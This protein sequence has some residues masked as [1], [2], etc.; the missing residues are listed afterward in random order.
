MQPSRSNRRNRLRVARCVAA[1]TV[2]LGAVASCATAE[3]SAVCLPD[4][5]SVARVWNEVALDAIRLDFPAPTVHARNLHHLSVA[6]WDSWVAYDD[7]EASAHTAKADGSSASRS[8]QE[9]AIA[10]AASRILSVRYANAIGGEETVATVDATLTALCLDPAMADDPDG[11]A[12]HGVAIADAVLASAADDGSRESDLYVAPFEVANEP[13]VLAEP[14]T[15]MTEPNRWQQLLFV[16]AMTQNGQLLESNLQDYVGP[17]WGAVTPFALTPSSTGLPIDPGP[18]PLLGTATEP[19]FV[20]GAVD[21]IDASSRLDPTDGE[22]LDIGP[23]ARG[24]NSLGTN[25]GSGHAVNPSTGEPYA[26]NVV[27]AAD[28]YRVIAEFWADG[29][30]SETPPG[31]W[32][33]L[34]NTAS[35]AL[36]EY[37]LGGSGETVDRLQWDVSLYFV[38]NGALHDAAIAAWG[39]KAHYDYVRPISMIRHLAGEGELPVVPGLIEVVTEASA[40]PGGHHADLV[41]HVGEPA[42]RAWARR[43]AWFDE[44]DQVRWIPASEWKPYQRP[45]FVTPAFP[46]YVSGHST[47]SRAAAEVLTALTGSEYFPGGMATHRV[48]AGQLEFDGGPSVDIELQWATYYDAADEAGLSRIYGGIH[49]AADDV[50]GRRMGADVGQIAVDHA[51]QYLG[52]DGALGG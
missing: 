9:V 52:H 18:P 11:P 51:A 14:G 2:C 4:D 10:F 22:M 40:A 15:T 44:V 42:I 37:R 12:A 6:M 34:A 30:S 16:Q 27:P 1:I 25:D 45:T 33:T 48:E 50:E 47:F 23:G 8:D 13:L 38:L 21:V 32:N 31:H 41:D 26:A 5:R 35:D 28:F 43:P 36:E 17:H 19:E 49:V 20:S 29:P 46:G 3:A 39:A 24:A 7:G